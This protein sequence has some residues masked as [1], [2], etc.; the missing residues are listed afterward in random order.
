M[1]IEDLFSSAVFSVYRRQMALLDWIG[2]RNWNYD[3]ATSSISFTDESPFETQTLGLESVHGIWMWAWADENNLPAASK[4]FAMEMKEFGLKNQISEFITPD[5]LT[6]SL[7][8]AGHTLA[9]I[10]A[11]QL[12]DCPYFVCSGEQAVLYVA[13]T[14][15]RFSARPKP[16]SLLEV[17]KVLPQLFA[18]YA[19]KDH[20]LAVISAFKELGVS[21]EQAEKSIRGFHNGML[22]TCEFDEAGR[23]REC[24]T[25]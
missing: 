12:R 22:L 6:D 2:D 8:C 3:M 20:R 24:T 4:R 16:L 17:A 25:Q 23:L 14:D 21:P 13:I 10:A 1:D 9:V 5:F 19:V 15:S 11:S 7:S 18:D